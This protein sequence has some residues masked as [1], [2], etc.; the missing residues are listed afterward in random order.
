VTQ[1]VL[2]SA[3]VPTR[4]SGR[5]LWACLESLRRQTHAPLEVIV[6]DNGST[7]DTVRI[8]Q[9]LGDVVVSKGPERS[10][11]RNEGARRASGS[12]LLFID[13]DMVLEP[14]VVAECLA[15]AAGGAGAVVIPETSFGEGYWARCKAL[16]RS[17]YVGDELIEAARFFERGAFEAS[18]GFDEEL[19]AGPEDWDLHE[20]V[21]AGGAR[22]GRTAALIHHDEGVLRLGGLARKKYYYGRAMADYRRK[23]PELARRQLS[24]VRPAFV[25]HWR[26]LAADPVPAAGMVVMKG[27]E[28]A[29]GGAGIALALA[30][31][32][33]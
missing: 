13:S 19:P 31:R 15:A 20:R 27:C 28:Y 26:R 9:T 6:V 25:R 16:E 24:V 4:N 30:R 33:Q 12:H 22:I 5:T 10:A 32:R 17:C 7:D 11:Q 2:V 14:D 1:A 29:A 8:A 3:I 18:G 21:R 23:H